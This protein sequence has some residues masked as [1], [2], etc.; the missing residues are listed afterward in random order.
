VVDN[1]K[2]LDLE[3][4]TGSLGVDLA[5][6]GDPMAKTQRSDQLDSYV[7]ETLAANAAVVLAKTQA[8][9]ARAESRD[10]AQ[11]LQS[12][13]ADHEAERVARE[14]AEQQLTAARREQAFVERD[15]AVAEARAD[16][17]RKQI[18]QERVER[19]ILLTRI[20]ELESERDDALAALG[21]W[22]RRRFAVRRSALNRGAAP[23]NDQK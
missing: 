9:A 6:D 3:R 10:L 20:T 15:R 18:E 19:S 16:E 11:Q 12:L 14:E 17:V 21:W 4:V 7:K 1:A 23:A 2:Q 13:A 8:T 22:S 5:V